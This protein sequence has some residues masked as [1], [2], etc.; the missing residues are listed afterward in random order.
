MTRLEIAVRLAAGV[1]ANG[2]E[3]RSLMLDSVRQV[4]HF[5]DA[6][7]D[8]E[9]SLPNITRKAAAA[10][11]KA[12]DLLRELYRLRAAT[13]FAGADGRDIEAREA[14]WSEVRE[15]LASLAP[16]TP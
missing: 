7:L 14:K 1:A 5:A 16:V 15:F 13:S 3:S 9:A 6:I 11:T 4:F 2:H 12:L 10:E 8:E